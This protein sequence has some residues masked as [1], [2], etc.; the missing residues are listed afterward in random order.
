MLATWTQT[1]NVKNIQI[2]RVLKPYSY[3]YFLDI[4]VKHYDLVEFGFIWQ[5]I[6]VLLLDQNTICYINEQGLMF[7]ELL[8]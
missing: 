6:N 4:F 1:S 8:Q 7:T 3:I 5:F 2:S